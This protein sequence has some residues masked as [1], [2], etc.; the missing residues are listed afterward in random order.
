LFLPWT[1]AL[2]S[3]QLLR[4]VIVQLVFLA[5][6]GWVI[7]GAIEFIGESLRVLRVCSASFP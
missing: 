2:A 5:A 4:G 7:S 1:G 3:G 6:L